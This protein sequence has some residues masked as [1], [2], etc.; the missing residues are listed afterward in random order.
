MACLNLVI[1]VSCGDLI[2]LQQQLDLHLPLVSEFFLYLFII[3][4]YLIYYLLFTCCWVLAKIY[5][6]IFTKKLIFSQD[7]LWSWILS[8]LSKDF[9]N[10]K[11]LCENIIYLAVG[12]KNKT[13]VPTMQLYATKIQIN[14]FKLDK[15][16]RKL[17]VPT[18]LPHFVSQELNQMAFGFPSLTSKKENLHP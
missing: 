17:D 15:C 11:F 8:P 4:I 1:G 14:I 10:I 13:C 5:F 2:N 9:K 16:S 3:L 6:L 12:K 7:S 18:I